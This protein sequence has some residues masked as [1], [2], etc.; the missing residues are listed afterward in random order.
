MAQARNIPQCPRIP[1]PL[2][3]DAWRQTPLGGQQHHHALVRGR[4]AAR[5]RPIGSQS[6]C[7]FFSSWIVGFPWWIYAVHAAPCLRVGWVWV[8]ERGGGGGYTLSTWGQSLEWAEGD[9]DRATRTKV[10]QLRPRQ[11]NRRSSPAARKHS[12]ACVSGRLACGAEASAQEAHGIWQCT[13]VAQQTG[14]TWE[15]DRTFLLREPQIVREIIL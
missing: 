14:G 2:A 12:V 11:A 8:L 4:S 1:A 7:A 15:E 9:T 13:R 5:L 3:A 10:A 6:T